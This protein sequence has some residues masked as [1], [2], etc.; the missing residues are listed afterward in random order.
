SWL[1]TSMNVSYA[2]SETNNNG[3]GS[4]SNSVFWFVDNIPSIYPLFLRDASGAKVPDPIFGGFQYDYGSTG[5]KFGSLTNAIADAHLNTSQAKRN[6]L[7]GNAD[8]TLKFLKNFS[9]V[10]SL[11]MQYY[12]N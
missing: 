3:Q 1:T 7:N 4:S 11:G 8:I 10:N 2:N 6:D 5:R 12:N 9:L